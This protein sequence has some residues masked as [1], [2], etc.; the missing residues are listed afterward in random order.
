MFLS[1]PPPLEVDAGSPGGE[2]DACRCCEKMHPRPPSGLPRSFAPFAKRR[3]GEGGVNG[4][5]G[6]NDGRGVYKYG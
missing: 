6:N 2:G 5:G 4:G 3:R 1:P